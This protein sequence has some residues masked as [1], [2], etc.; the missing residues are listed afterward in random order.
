MSYFSSSTG[1]L[2]LKAREKLVKSLL[3]GLLVVT[4]LSQNKAIAASMTFQMP[5]TPQQ[6]ITENVVNKVSPELKKWFGALAAIF[7]LHS[8]IKR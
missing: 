6:F 5:Y 2:P 7:A 3:V 8:L 4:T 1:G